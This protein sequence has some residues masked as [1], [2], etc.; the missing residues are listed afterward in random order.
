MILKSTFVLACLLACS[1]LGAGT[2]T[3]QNTQETKPGLHQ[4]GE[5]RYRLQPG[6]VIEVQYR[7]T[8]E[9]NQTMTIQPD[10]F[11]ILEI[12]GELKISDAT[13][14]QAR[15]RIVERAGA[16]LMNPEVTLLLKEFQKPYFVVSGE[17]A[18]PGKFEMREQVTALQAVMLAGGFKNSGRASQV[19]VFRRINSETAEVLVVNLKNIKRTDALER[20]LILRPGDMLLVPQNTFSKIERFV[21]MASV[22]AFLRL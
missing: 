6:D 1:F 7:Y 8:P 17:V 21:S 16:R 11:V 22:L 9:F 15:T 4:P 10:G 12:V 5:G 13:I 3:A 2:A 19:V 14:E 18:Q 20:D